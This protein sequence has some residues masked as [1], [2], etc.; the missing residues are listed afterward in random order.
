MLD[1]ANNM[2]WQVTRLPPLR[3]PMATVNLKIYWRTA[4]RPLQREQGALSQ[5]LSA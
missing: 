2:L 3:S 5:I 4:G 1:R